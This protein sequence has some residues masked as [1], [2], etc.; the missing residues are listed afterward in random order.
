MKNQMIQQGDVLLKPV[1]QIPECKRL[2]TRTLA[3]G[4]ATGHHHTFE[5]GVCVMEAPTGERYVINETQE[6]KQL[7]HQE[8]DPVT[9]GAGEMYQFGQVR[10]YDWFQQME[11]T[12]Q[13]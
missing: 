3:L 7:L 4:E 9:I 12:V 6:P 5:P 13:D 11:R 1:S 10:E 8:H 2:Q